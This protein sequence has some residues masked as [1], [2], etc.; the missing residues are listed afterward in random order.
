MENATDRDE[1]PVAGF[2]SIEIADETIP[3]NLGIMFWHR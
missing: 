3:A 2:H 1:S